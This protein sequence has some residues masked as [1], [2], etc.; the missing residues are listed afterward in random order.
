VPAAV[1]CPAALRG[2]G[3]QARR[4]AAVSLIDRVRALGLAAG[5]A[6]VGVA[7]ADPFQET[8]AVLE[9]RRAV[10]LAA[11]MQFTY[12]N[13]ARSTDPGRALPGARSLVVGAR[14]YEREPTAGSAHEGSGVTA[15]VARY[16]WVDHYAE[17]R[18]GLEVMAEELRADGWRTVVLADDNALVD[19]AAAQRAGIGWYGKNTNIL[20]PG[21]GSWFVLGSVV[22]DAVLEPDEPVPD[23]CGSCRRC[24]PA[25]P[26][27]A[28]NEPGVLDARR[29][30]AWLVQAPGVFPPEH[31]VALG[32]R[33]Y[34]CDDCQEVCPV[35]RLHT[36]RQPPPPAEGQARA[37]VDALAVLAATDTEL[38]TEF[39]RW[40]IAGREVRWLRRNALLVVGNTADASRP[41]VVTALRRALADPDP[42]VRGPAVWAAARL[43]L[44]AL[45]PDTDE[46]P[47][48]ARELARVPSVPS[49]S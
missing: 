29:C 4:P 23:G 31:R 22:T 40:Y 8:R 34:G 26:T 15:R 47:D 13:P 14:S 49:R 21:A 35:N 38:L 6:A 37:A 25:C 19:R 24:M 27:G 44:T 17:L 2:E 39:G 41:D 42:A 12:R 46:D 16:S 45:L 10:G 18:R 11:D 30:L 32:D 3:T 36:R 5:L 9:A 33:L 7:T 43:G 20:L 1:R 28:L 48:V